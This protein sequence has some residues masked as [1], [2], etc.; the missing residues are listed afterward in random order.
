M[1]DTLFRTRV[2]ADPSVATDVV[3]CTV[4]LGGADEVLQVIIP[5]AS[6]ECEE[7]SSNGERENAGQVWFFPTNCH[8]GA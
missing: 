8:T 4:S 1:L 5:E 2:T 6:M 7:T 3:S